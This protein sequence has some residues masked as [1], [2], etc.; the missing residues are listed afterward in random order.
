[1]PLRAPLVLLGLDV[2]DPDQLARWMAEGHLPAL[3][4]LVARGASGR[5]AG[6]EMACEHAVWTTVFSGRSLGEHGYYYYRRLK[7]GSYDLETITGADVDAPP[8]WARFADG[9]RRCAIVDAPDCLPIDGIDG[10]QISD[11][12]IH[13]APFPARVTPAA[14]ADVVREAG[15]GSTPIDEAL[16]SDL[17]AD[18]RIYRRLMDRVRRKGAVCR[19]VMDRGPFDLVVA[20]FS[21]CHTATHQFWKYRPEAGGPDTELRHAT[22]DVYQ[23]IDRELQAI[24]ARTPEH[25]N[26]CSVGSTG[27]IDLY[28]AGD[29]MDPFCRLLEYQ[30]TPLAG[31]PSMAP[32]AV[33]RRMLP[34]WLRVAVSRRFPRGVRERLLADRFRAA[35]DWSRTLAFGLPSA[36]TGFIRVNLQGREPQGIVAPG[37]EYEAL[38]DRIEADL[39]QLRDP[40]TG[41]V[42]VASVSRTGRLFGR[43]P[44]SL[45]DLMVEW[46]PSR[47]FIER[48]EHPRGE[49]AQ[50]RPEFFRDSDHSRVGFIAVAGPAIARGDLGTIAPT[51]LAPLFLSLMGE[52]VASSMRRRRS[53]SADLVEEREEAVRK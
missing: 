24:L 6:P 53:R 33:A 4:A 29:L 47:R 48:L 2:G 50:A 13:N 9:S 31:A 14:F 11:W 43:M 30:A 1:M 36:F 38:L 20:V 16:D 39:W 25:A 49:I 44:Q 27:M 17:A 45:P 42:P 8:F 15:G 35:T 40:E 3:R 37:A 41:A 26:V 22:R 46:K 51:D 28:P 34:E 10:V 12:A 7:P 23:A 5:L 19:A 32:L 18:R 52:P 21:D